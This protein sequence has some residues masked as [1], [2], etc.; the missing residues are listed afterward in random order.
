MKKLFLILSLLPVI[1]FSQTKKMLDHSDYDVWRNTSKELI[2]ND[3]SSIAYTTKTNG[4]GNEELNLHQFSGA[5][6]LFHDRASSPSFSNDSKHLIFKVKP[7]FYAVQDMKRKKKKEKDLPVDTLAIYNIGSKS[8][9]KIAGLKSFKVP[10]KWDGYVMY[11]YEPAPDTAKAKKKE[12]KRSKKNGYD[13]VVRN[14]ID[15]SEVTFS[16][17]LDYEIAEEGAALAIITT[18]NDST[19]TKGVYSF[20]FESKT[21]KPVF[22]AKGDY[23]QLTWD[24]MGK[25]LSFISDTDT[26]K[27]LQ[28]DFHLHYYKTNWDSSKTIAKNADLDQLMVNSNFSNYFSESG[29]RLFFETKEF[30]VLQDTALLK[31][32]IVNVEVWNYKD[33]RLFTQQENQKKNDERFGYTSYYDCLLYTSPSPRD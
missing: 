13:L 12:K 16:Y 24:K 27:A 8:L 2:S 26:T 19:I 4:Y 1:G 22:R 10:E 25:Q 23:S 32:E 21:F 30:P 6:I 11:L 29:K 3:G 14:L 31:D 15:Q 18:G 20:D 33:Q 9:N 5:Q 7:D 28:R 17:V